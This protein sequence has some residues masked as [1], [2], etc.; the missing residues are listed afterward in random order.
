MAEPDFLT[1]TRTSYDTIAATYTEWVRKELAIRPVDRAML[2]AFAE[3]V[4]REA[5][6]R[7]ADI[8]CGPGRVTSYLANLGADAFGI[9]LSSGMVEQARAAYPTLRFEVGSMLELPLADQS[10]G[11][12]VAW[13]SIIHVPDELLPQAFAEFRRVLIA[14]GH[15]LLGFQ[16]GTGVSHRDEAAGHAV[17]LD[18]RYR[19]LD[20]VATMLR[21]SGFDV[22]TRLTREPDDDPDYPEKTPQGFLLARNTEAA[23]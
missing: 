1:D 5:N 8:G 18:F 19:Q 20:D 7:I 3:L 17:S 15:V 23:V 12:I 11:G 13:Y 16:V 21:E 2:T 14:G 10:L 22:R 6:S 9:D 4:A